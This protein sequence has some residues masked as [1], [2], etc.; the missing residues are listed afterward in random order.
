MPSN[1]KSSKNSPGCAA[2]KTRRSTRASSIA[3]KSF[4]AD[5]D[6]DYAEDTDGK[7]SEEASLFIRLNPR[8]PRLIFPDASLLYRARELAPRRTTADR[9]RS[10]PLP[11]R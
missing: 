11:Q 6:R 1:V 10:P 3:P 4:S 8:H 9:L 7:K 5:L 2:K